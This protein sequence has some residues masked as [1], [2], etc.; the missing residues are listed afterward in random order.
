MELNDKDRK[1]L[2]DLFAKLAYGG[3]EAETAARMIGDMTTRLGI[4]GGDLQSLFLR[5]SMAATEAD[6]KDPEPKPTEKAQPEPASPKADVSGNDEG[7]EPFD[8]EEGED[9][10]SKAVSLAT[11]LNEDGEWAELEQLANCQIIMDPQNAKKWRSI[12]KTAAKARRH[13]RPRIVR[14]F[15]LLL[16]VIAGF[17]ALVVAAGIIGAVLHH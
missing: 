16:K 8:Y 15:L 3:A 5:G 14:L 1:R 13:Q 11:A 12:A 10:N 6:V 9:L 17:F 2:A 7:F 4:S